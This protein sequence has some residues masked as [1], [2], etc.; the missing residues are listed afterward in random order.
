MSPCNLPA[1]RDVALGPMLEDQFGLPTFINNDGDLFAYGEAT[2]GFL[3]YVNGLLEKAGSPK[4][5]RNLLG[6]H[7]GHRLRR[8]HRARWRVVH[9]R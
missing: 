5:Y 3:P 1:Y 4:R 6:R 8:R 7:A 2:A 9:R